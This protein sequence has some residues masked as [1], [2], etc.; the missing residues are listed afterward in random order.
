MSFLMRNIK[1]F[2]EPAREKRI[3]ALDSERE[4][5]L[6]P[7]T[8]ALELLL[9]A[10]VAVVICTSQSS[11]ALHSFTILVKAAYD[12]NRAVSL[13]VGA[14]VDRGWTVSV[15]SGA[16]EEI[17]E[18]YG[19]IFERN[20]IHLNENPAVKDTIRNYI[21]D[22]D[23]EDA[24]QFVQIVEGG[25]GH[26]YYS[27]LSDHELQDECN[28]LRIKAKR[29]PPETRAEL[30]KRAKLINRE[31]EVITGAWDGLPSIFE[32][33]LLQETKDG[34]MDPSAAASDAL[35]SA[36][37]A[38]PAALRAQIRREKQVI[39][40]GKSGGVEW[41]GTSNRELYNALHT[42]LDGLL[43]DTVMYDT[44]AKA[45]ALIDVL[46]EEGTNV[47]VAMSQDH[48]DQDMAGMTMLMMAAQRRMP[49]TVDVIIK[50]MQRTMNARQVELEIGKSS[51]QGMTALLFTL[52]GVGK[53]PQ[54]MDGAENDVL[55]IMK[56]LLKLG[57]DPSAVSTH[58]H[59][60]DYRIDH[61]WS[62]L[63]L[64]YKSYK[65]RVTQ[66][67][68]QYGAEPNMTYYKRIAD[69]SREW[70]SEEVER[71][72]GDRFRAELQAFRRRKGRSKE[73]EKRRLEEKRR[74][75]RERRLSAKKQPLRRSKRRKR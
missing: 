58:V 63:G 28:H 33:M 49:R 66:L 53:Y 41:R 14:A 24:V 67:L 70:D 65:P 7:L 36:A 39:S 60:D 74:Q 32:V 43:V 73:E 55:H 42:E 27:S 48:E 46:A 64:A 31:V 37:A 9:S 40:A 22:L 72:W 11:S 61:T 20:S 4:S 8:P 29:T 23:H 13:T 30:T 1:M 69:P 15:E 47:S 59:P 51:K 26:S 17:S 52:H 10:P 71:Q 44:D 19:D 54:K 56:A 75:Q 57:A 25:G 45:A 12:L 3:E 68:L 21:A 34:V 38:G 2:S 5:L 18:R 35:Q 62:T 16:M 50:A 6:P